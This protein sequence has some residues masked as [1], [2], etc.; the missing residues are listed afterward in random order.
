MA[1][2]KKKSTTTKK[3]GSSKSSSSSKKGGKQTAS[4]PPQEPVVPI[5]REVG[6]VIFLFL[7]VFVTISYFRSEGSFIMFLQIC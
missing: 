7:A 4:Q 5:R 2:T 1:Q 3:S 6:A